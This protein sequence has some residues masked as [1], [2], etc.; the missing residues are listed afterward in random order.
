[1]PYK[2]P[3]PDAPAPLSMLPREATPTASDLLYL[4]KPNNVIGQRCKA[5][6]LGALGARSTGWVDVA[7]FNIG[8]SDVSQS[9]IRFKVPKG[10]WGMVELK[11]HMA[12][13]YAAATGQAGRVIKA[14]L[15]TY[16]INEI[17]DD[18]TAWF[19]QVTMNENGLVSEDGSYQ[20]KPTD[21]YMFV[22]IPKCTL[23]TEPAERTIQ[24][25]FRLD[26]SASFPWAFTSVKARA[27]IWMQADTLE[28]VSP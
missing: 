23:T 16:D 12:T 3:L 27:T 28:V 26:T 20:G 24:A 8:A 7:D 14:A 5:V 4:V 9:V 25:M 21:W 22:N 15:K 11:F 1:M 10:W 18:E 17:D 13:S 19:T 6:E 2:F